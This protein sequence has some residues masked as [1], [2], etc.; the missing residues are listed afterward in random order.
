MAG[1]LPCNGDGAMSVAE[2]ISFRAEHSVETP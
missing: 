2:V 1:S